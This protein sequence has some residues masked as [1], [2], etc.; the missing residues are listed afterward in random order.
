[1][2]TYQRREST[3]GSSTSLWIA[4]RRV[5]QWRDR[6]VGRRALILLSLTLAL[7]GCAGDPRIQQHLDKVEAEIASQLDASPERPFIPLAWLS[8]RK[9]STA[10][11]CILLASSALFQPGP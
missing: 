11:T 5:L 4:G 9:S 8:A 6:C 3:R 10:G 2:N 7:D 1:M